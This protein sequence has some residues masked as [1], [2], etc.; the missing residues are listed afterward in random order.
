MIQQP[1]TRFW[2]WITVAAVVSGLE[3][4]KC[5]Q[6]WIQVYPRMSNILSRR[7]RTFVQ[8]SHSHSIFLF[9]PDPTTTTLPRTFG[10]T[11]KKTHRDWIWAPGY[12]IYPSRKIISI[13]W[14]LCAD[15]KLG[16][17]RPCRWSDTSNSDQNW[18]SVI[19][20]MILEKLRPTIAKYWMEEK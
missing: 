4:P 14:I 13:G 10:D 1:V 11:V 12:I 19:T 15:Q 5:V 7:R 8:W 18:K 6:R 9:C 16:Y 3:Q 17:Q 20:S 2:P